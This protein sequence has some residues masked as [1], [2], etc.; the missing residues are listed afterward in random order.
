M[1]MKLQEGDDVKPTLKGDKINMRINATLKQRYDA[2]LTSAGISM[3]DH[4]TS[5]IFELVTSEERRLKR[6]QH[7]SVT[8]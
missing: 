1:P 3:T 8:S 6:L 7:E 2:A 4:L 5:K